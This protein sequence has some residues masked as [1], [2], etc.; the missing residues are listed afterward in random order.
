MNRSGRESR[1]IILARAAALAAVFLV[2]QVLAAPFDMAV[3]R[4]THDANYHKSHLHEL[5]WHAGRMEAW[6]AITIAGLL[7]AGSARRLRT[8]RDWM[9]NGSGLLVVCAASGLAAELL[10]RVVGRERP[11][12]RV[13]MDDPAFGEM[14][15][16]PLLAF[17]NDSNLGWPSSHAAVAVAAAASV[18]VMWRPAWPVAAFFALGCCYQR[19]ASS[20]HVLSDVVGGAA[21]GVVACLVLWP[22]L[23]RRPSGRLSH[24]RSR[25]PFARTIGSGG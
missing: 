14:A 17:I 25:A 19:L 16:R 9:M 6:V 2:P 10:K 13:G 23:A 21:I 5:Y 20:A 7:V 3:L 15:F 24:H 8:A 1:A 22:V 4:A 12:V 18:W 11:N